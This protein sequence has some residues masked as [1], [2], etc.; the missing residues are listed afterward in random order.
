MVKISQ[1]ITSVQLG[2][3]ENVAFNLARGCKLG[4]SNNIEFIIVELY[5]TK[6][7]YSKQKRKEISSKGI[8]II[9]LS[10]CSKRISLIIAPF[11][12]LIH[13]LKEK[14]QIIHSHTDL[15]DFVLAVCLRILSLLHIS[16]PKII[17]TI[18]NTELWSTHDK[19]ARFTEKTF[20]NDWIIGVSEVS[21]KAYNQIRFKNHLHTSH[22]QNIIHNGCSIP[23]NN[24]HPFKIDKLKINIAFCGR[25]ENQK[26]IDILLKR[27]QEISKRFNNKFAFHLIGNGTYMNEVNRLSSAIES[28]QVYA[29]VPNISDKL[30]AFDFII[31]PS[32]FEG[33][34]LLS[35]EASFSKVP[36]IA[37][38]APGLTETLPTDWPLLFHLD[39]SEEL[40]V[41]IQKI[42]NKK[43]NLKVLKE[44]AFSFV[45]EN[46][47]L[48]RMI[49]SYSK[50]YLDCYEQKA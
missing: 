14:P 44:D 31:M 37:A 4:D 26:G 7:N 16:C 41:I 38:Y 30:Y 3:A 22:Y 17:R 34:A 18:H 9:S 43:L 48:N 45:N 8:R 23:V 19:I 11:S 39:S 10:K 27:I 6:N 29:S 46:F 13:V 33:L 49:K 24:K 35:L 12:L 1:L 15:P 47:S 36:V 5:Q 25:F 2:G 32:R 50:I 21:L 40:M 28:V 20:E 42:L